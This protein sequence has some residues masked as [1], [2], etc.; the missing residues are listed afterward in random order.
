MKVAPVSV[1]VTTLLA[2]TL[3][4]D[5]ADARLAGWAHAATCL[6]PR[7]FG[8]PTAA[9][10]APAEMGVPVYRRMAT[11]C[12]R[13][14]SEARP[15]RG[16]ASLVATANAACPASATTTLPATLRTGPAIVWQDGQARTALNRVPQA[17]GDSNAPKPASVIMEGPATPRTGAV[18]APQ[19]GLDLTAWKAAHQ[20]CLVSTAPRYVSVVLER[21]ATQRLG[22]VSAPQDTVVHPAR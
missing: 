1:T 2:V 14:G 8:G 5:A 19:A 6:A 17:T 3:F 12:V 4:M 10:L 20:E 15:A 21:G 18:P 13:R 11:V 7:A 16:P 9:T 22:P